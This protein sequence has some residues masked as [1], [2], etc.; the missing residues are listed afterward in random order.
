MAFK[1]MVTGPR[2]AAAIIATTIIGLSSLVGCSSGTAT[3]QA[4]A[5]AENGLTPLSVIVAPIHFEAA[6]IADRNGFF[7]KQGLDVDIRPGADAQANFAQALSGDVGI[8]ITSWTVMVTSNAENVP[9]TA[10]ASNGYIAEGAVGSGVLVKPGSDIKSI[11]DLSG[12]T[13]GVQGVRSGSDLAVLLA[14]E[15]AGIDPNS[16]N[17]VAIPFPGMQAALESGQVDAIM[18]VEPF[19]SQATKA[20]MRDLGNMQAEYTPNVPSTVWAA[21][22]DWLSKNPDTATKFVAAMK[23]AA[24][25]YSDP[26]NLDEVRAITAEINQTDISKVSMNPAAIQVEFDKAAVTKNIADLARLGYTTKEVSF[27][28]VVWDKAPLK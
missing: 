23:E 15:D 5:G 24:T 8:V 16:I 2:R 4:E 6:Q 19:F 17:Q 1:Q 3:D 14:A 11:A 25:Y 13:L 12:K 28:E 7:E 20:G 21:T 22:D 27:D 26:K 18:T 10:V 9:V